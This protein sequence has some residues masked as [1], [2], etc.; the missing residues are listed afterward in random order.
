MIHIE[1]S[2]ISREA[3]AANADYMKKAM[4]VLHRSIT[5]RRERWPSREDA[6]LWMSKRAP[7]RDWDPRVLALFVVRHSTSK[8]LRKLNVWS[9]GS[10]FGSSK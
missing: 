6:K 4:S 10:L 5:K 3:F 7:W 2:M 8:Y 1:P 9:L